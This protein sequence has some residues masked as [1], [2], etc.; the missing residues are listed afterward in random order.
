MTYRATVCIADEHEILIQDANI[1][2]I[3]QRGQIEVWSADGEDHI[4]NL[5]E[6]ATEAQI[7]AAALFWHKGFIVGV[8]YGRRQ[9]KADMRK[10][11]GI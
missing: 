2:A 10:A 9:A 1:F 5:P 7:R 3:R 8:D 6:D 11:I 4:G